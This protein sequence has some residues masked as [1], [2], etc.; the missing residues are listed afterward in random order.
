MLKVSRYAMVG[1]VAVALL[2][3]CA[4]P[5]PVASTPAPSVTTPTPTSPP[6]LSD[7]D[8][9]N[10]AVSQYEKLDAII[11]EVDIQ[12][13]AVALPDSSRDV[14]MDPAWSTFNDLYLQVLM[15]GNKYVGKPETGITALARLDGEELAEGTVI[16]L[17]TCEL[18]EG[19]AMVDSDGNI[20]QDGSRVIRHLKAYLKYDSDSQLKVF[21]LNEETVDSCPIV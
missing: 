13:G 5:G 17:Q 12:G 4:V 19:A 20:L 16:A 3:G 9:Y 18:F 11:T 1:L 2:T 7:D 15:S 21:V 6:S 14:M 8:L 10:L